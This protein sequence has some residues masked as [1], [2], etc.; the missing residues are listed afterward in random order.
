MKVNIA[1]KDSNKERITAA[2][3]EAEGRATARRVCFDDVKKAAE[4]IERRFGIT[5]KAMVGMVVKV[6]MNAQEFPMA[7]RYTPSSTQFD[8]EKTA[9]GWKLTNIGRGDTGRVR[10]TVRVMPDHTKEAVMHKFTFFDW[11]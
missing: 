9:T 1:V 10:F 4:Q 2:I 7:Y 5:K 11:A 8:L 3:K 6:D